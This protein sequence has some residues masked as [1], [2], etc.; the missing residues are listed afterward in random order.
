MVNDMLTQ[1]KK[2]NLWLGLALLGSLSLT[3][4]P[5]SAAAQ[6]PAAGEKC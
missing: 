4:V 1:R 5:G 2:R 3:W 6:Q